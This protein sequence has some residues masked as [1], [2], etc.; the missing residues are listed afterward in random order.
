MVYAQIRIYPGE[1]DVQ[2]S[3]GFWDTNRSQNPSLTTK[4]GN[5]QQNRKKERTCRQM[6]FAVLAGHR[7]KIKEEKR[8]EY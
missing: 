4:P 2:N 6:N 5:S 3:L 7:E 8:D 1:S